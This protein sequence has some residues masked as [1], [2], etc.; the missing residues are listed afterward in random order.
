MVPA[1]QPQQ[2]IALAKPE[3]SFIYKTITRIIHDVAV[4][5]FALIAIVMMGK[6]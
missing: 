4:V 6:L 5:L 1:V 3:R 2:N